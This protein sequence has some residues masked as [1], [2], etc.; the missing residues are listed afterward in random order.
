LTPASAAA[1]TS[2]AWL[3]ALSRLACSL[4]FSLMER[5]FALDS[6]LGACGGL[7]DLVLLL[8]LGTIA[9]SGGLLG[10]VFHALHL[11][12]L[13]LERLTLCATLGHDDLALGGAFDDAGGVLG[14]L[15]LDL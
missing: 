2:L 3:M 7:L 13:G 12:L 4:A 10:G 8:L 11:G 9:G 14:T 6:G 5:L 15:L 1:N